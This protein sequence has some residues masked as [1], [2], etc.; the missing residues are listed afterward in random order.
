MIVH[1]VSKKVIV[2]DADTPHDAAVAFFESMGIPPDRWGE[3]VLVTEWDG[4]VLRS[5]EYVTV[6]PRDVEQS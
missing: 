4:K 6:H 5:F 1:E 2:H 3:A